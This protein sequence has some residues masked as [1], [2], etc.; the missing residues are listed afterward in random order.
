M[1]AACRAY[2]PG[3]AALSAQTRPMYSFISPTLADPTR[4]FRGVRQGRDS[5]GGDLD[6]DR[7]QA[8]GDAAREVRE[9]AMLYEA[10]AKRFLASLS[11]RYMKARET[12]LKALMGKM[13]G[14]AG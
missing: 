6:A 8:I 1:R 5:A 7:K 12:R 3:T 14:R 4:A 2:D 13:A 10:D 9:A 11:E